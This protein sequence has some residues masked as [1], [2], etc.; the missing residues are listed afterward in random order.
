MPSRFSKNSVGAFCM[1]VAVAL[2]ETDLL[3]PENRTS[4]Q[5]QLTLRDFLGKTT[6]RGRDR[7]ELNEIQEA[8]RLA[9]E[10][11]LVAP[12]DDRKLQ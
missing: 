2:Q 8:L 7:R 3:L 6:L 12:P 4:H 11:A 1:G 9:M 10:T 5:F